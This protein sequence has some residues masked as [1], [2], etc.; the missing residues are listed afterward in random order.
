M[1]A[2]VA[3]KTAQIDKSGEAGRAGRT[4]SQLV[5]HILDTTFDTLPANVVHATKRVILDTIAVTVGAF[6][7]PVARALLKLKR[8]AGGR[9]DATLILDGTKLP[10]P[11]AAYVNAQL[12]NL[13]DADETLLN[14]AHF[15]S[16]SVM[17]ALAI[18]EKV[19]ASGK[20]LIAAVATGFD[21]TARIGFSLHQYETN[22][23]GNVVFAPLFGFGWMSF[24]AAA[25]AGKLLGLD[26][27]QL[28]HALGQAFVTTPLVY[29][30]IRANKP[31]Y[32]FGEPAYWHRY[33]MSG[34]ATEAGVNAAL[35]AADGFV[36]RTDIFDEGSGFWQSFCAP[37]CDWDFMYGE[38]GQRWFIEET[39]IKRWPSCRLGH[40]ALDLFDE[41]VVENGLLPDDIEEIVVRAS[42]NETVR[43]L[44]EN[45]L[46]EDPLKLVMSL[47]TAYGLIAHRVPPGPQWWNDV[48]DIEIRKV[49]QKVRC[50]LNE[51]WREIVV[52]QVM[53]DGMFRQVPTE[54]IVRTRKGEHRKFAEYAVGDP[55]AAGFGMSDEQLIEKVRIFTD[56]ALPTQKTDA[57]IRAVMA[58]DHDGDTR[59]VAAA[60][61]R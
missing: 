40:S 4:T 13:L 35:L 7:T 9:E 60:M 26:K 25:A 44:T 42:P 36:A 21:L 6:D 47:P 38:L 30:I 57:L 59:A 55:W 17:A 24:G 12:A 3:I 51:D 41:I 48:T 20:D 39:S 15:A 1:G 27:L 45:I 11:S 29:D 43:A 18:G 33:Q 54:V 37:G 19:G 49:A 53:S 10:A 50:E 14:R 23:D 32:E 5:D 28:A 34:A 46:I 52:K 22:A 2:G 16:A 56:Q 58:L 31:L 8:D 61:V